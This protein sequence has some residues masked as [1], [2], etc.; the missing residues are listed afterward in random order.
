MEN[1]TSNIFLYDCMKRFSWSCF[2]GVFSSND[3][4]TQLHAT[5][6][7]NIICNLSR[8]EEQGTHFIALIRKNNVLMYLDPLALYIEL[9]DDISQFISLCNC[10]E[11]I[12]LTTPVQHWKS[13][14]CGYFCLFFVLYYSDNIVCTKLKQF[15]NENIRKNDCICLHNL[16]H[17]FEI[18]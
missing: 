12:K 1:A 4:P 5:S 10:S 3:I 2:W 15:E 18:N 13:W 7:F 14:Y 16:S 11:V 6:E 8:K 9:N 17:I